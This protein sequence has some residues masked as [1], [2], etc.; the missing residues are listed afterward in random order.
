MKTV[1][2]VTLALASASPAFAA[3][4]PLVDGAA[5]VAVHSG[6]M[7]S[8]TIVP[9]A[10]VIVSTSQPNTVA[11]ICQ[12]SGAPVDLAPADVLP[13]NPGTKYSLGTGSCMTFGRPAGIMVINRS[14]GSNATLK[15]C[16]ENYPL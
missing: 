2:F 9:Y 16:I 1:V 10:K 15:Y 14:F 3:C 6:A 8:G 13:A 7:I 5:T 11:T 4:N 12:T